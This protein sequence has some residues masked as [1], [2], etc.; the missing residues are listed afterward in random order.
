MDYGDGGSPYLLSAKSAG[1]LDSI[2]ARIDYQLLPSMRIF[3]RYSDSTSNAL[4]DS[5]G[6]PY[7]SN[8]VGRNQVYLLGADNTFGVSI[9]NELRLQYSPA[10]F[11]TVATPSSAGGAVPFNLYGSNGVPS[12]AGEQ[13]FRSNRHP[14]RALRHRTAHRKVQESRP[15]IFRSSCVFRRR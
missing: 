13:E 10:V 9:S 3:A 14:S 7:T 2:N 12:G 8:L 5:T 11:K 6:G 1:V 15:E 4:N